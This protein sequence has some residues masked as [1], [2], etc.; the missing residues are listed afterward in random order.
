MP[1]ELKR[2]HVAGLVEGRVVHYVPAMADGFRDPERHR[3]AQVV[4]VWSGDTGMVNLVVT[5]DGT[6]DR[7]DGQL[8]FWATSIQFDPE[9]SERSWHWIEGSR[10]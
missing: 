1:D 9:G 7:A 4:R 8:H 5:C 6:N 2:M 10:G 3:A